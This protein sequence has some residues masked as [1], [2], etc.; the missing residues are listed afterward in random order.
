MKGL[1]RFL[2]SAAATFA[3]F[4]IFVGCGSEP[5]QIVRVTS[6]VSTQTMSTGGTTAEVVSMVAE[7]VVE[8]RTE[9]VT[10]QWGMQYVVS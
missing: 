8:I 9:S 6:Y 4:G 3:A 7:S 1:K 2:Y 10:T 5:Q